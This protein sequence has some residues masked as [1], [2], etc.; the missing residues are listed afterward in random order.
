M[1]TSHPPSAPRKN[2]K[3]NWE[4]LTHDDIVEE[5]HAYRTELYER[6]GGDAEAIFHYYQEREPQNA[7]RRPTVKV[8]PRRILAQ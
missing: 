4:A 7:G 6:F 5:N 8:L 1:A 3:E 2:W